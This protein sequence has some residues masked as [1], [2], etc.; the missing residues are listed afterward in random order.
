MLKGLKGILEKGLRI[1]APIIGT[2]TPLGPIFGAAAGSGI[3]S[4]IAGDKPR[5]ALLQAGLAGLGGKFGLFGGTPAQAASSGSS[6]FQVI[7]F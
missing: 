4:L 2:A 1:A 6:G 5:D 7:L 3:A